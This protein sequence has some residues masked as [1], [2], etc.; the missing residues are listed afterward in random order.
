MKPVYGLHG[1]SVRSAFAWPDLFEPLRI[2]GPGDFDFTAGASAGA[3]NG[4][5][6]VRFSEPDRD[7]AY[8]IAEGDRS[9]H[10]VWQ[11]DVPPVDV[12]SIFA[13]TVLRQLAARTGRIALH[14][15]AV[16]HRDEAILFVGPKG[17]GKSSLFAAGCAA[18]LVPLADDLAIPYE[19]D[20]GWRM[21]PGMPLGRLRDDTARR[22]GLSGSP[23]LPLAPASAGK[24]LYRMS[25]RSADPLR[26]YRIRAVHVLAPRGG[27]GGPVRREPLPA[28]AAFAALLGETH[29][30]TPAAARAVGRLV[31]RVPVVGLRRSDD[32]DML[33]A[34][35]LS[36]AADAGW[37]LP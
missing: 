18:G 7:L 13:N 31:T 26:E 20:G 5:A 35:V 21:K 33:P 28:P 37:S 10:A 1:L 3:P 29:A 27:E 34:T 12:V 8:T 6:V 16:G 24:R 2:G 36:V 4:G 19:A 14:A 23:S 32:L 25:D 9:V 22:F 15:A 11:G 17:A 30:P